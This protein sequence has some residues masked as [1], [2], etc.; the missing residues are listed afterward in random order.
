MIETAFT[1]LVD[2]VL[3]AGDVVRQIVAEVE[4]ILSSLP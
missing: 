1:R 2:E 3:P 4:E